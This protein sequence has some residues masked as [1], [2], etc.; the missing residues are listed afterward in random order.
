[1][2]KTIA[3]A[4]LLTLAGC[5][6]NVAVESEP[7]PSTDESAVV[8]HE[9]GGAYDYAVDFQGQRVTGVL[10]VAR[11]GSGYG[12][13]MQSSAGAVQASNVRRLR[14]TLFMDVETPAGSGTAELTWSGP[15]RFT[16]Y[17]YLDSSAYT[18]QGT[19]RP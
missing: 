15:A 18:I 2:K 1:M 3:L 16:G 17:V 6:R 11:S 12:V 10:N 7:S 8:E 13:T 19:R 9:I 14:D 4:L 5:T